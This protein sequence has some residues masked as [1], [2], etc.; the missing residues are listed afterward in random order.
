MLFAIMVAAALVITARLGYWQMARHDDL[1]ELAVNLRERTMTE[2]AKRGDIITSDGVLL[3]TDIFYYEVTA[4]PRL[5]QN[6]KEQAQVLAPILNLSEAELV[7]KLSDQRQ[8]TVM[9]TLT[10]P[11]TAGKQLTALRNAGKIG[12][13]EFVAKPQRRYPGGSLAAHLVGFTSASRSGAY[14]VEQYFDELL[15]GRDGQIRAEADALGD[16]ALPFDLP[17]GSPALN[18]SSLVLTINSALQ[19]I[20]ER[21]VARGVQEFGARSG[22]IL[23]LDPQ[24]GKIL[25][26][27]SYPAPD[28]NAFATTKLDAYADPAVSLPYEPGSVFKAFTLAAG[29][30][31]GKISRGIVLN[32]PGSVVIG[33]R[34]I[35]NS[36]RKGYGNV[37]LVAAMAKSLNVIASKIALAT[38]PKTFYQYLHD[39]GFGTLSNVDLAGE[40]PGTVKNPGDGI[41]YESD[42]GTN[43]FGQGIAV[44]PLQ[45]ANALAVI[46]NG[47]K[48]MRPYI[49]ERIIHPDGSVEAR[50]PYM[51]RRVLKPET[52]AQVTD[53]LSRSILTESTNKANLPGYTIAGKTGTAQIPVPGGYD[54]K[55]TIASFGGYLPADN[56]QYVILVKIDRPQKSP[57]GSQVASPIFAAVAQ[58]IAQLTGLPPDDIRKAMSK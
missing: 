56:P 8:Q 49:V 27:A 52:A 15:R 30:D 18:G 19:S 5:I 42:L 25:A 55:W 22:Q 46:A 35:Y 12:A 10:A 50:S 36:D 40:I 32:D 17:Q 48:L 38:G 34:A 39:F 31:S 26:L 14:G 3:A 51:V 21:E 9:L 37:D 13:I 16:E 24:T 58:Q 7:E 33:G 23:I 6:P 1:G 57:W 47:G 41:W 44:T 11:V 20:A 43:S 4:H 45:M 54:P 53:I 28:L 2:Y 29:L